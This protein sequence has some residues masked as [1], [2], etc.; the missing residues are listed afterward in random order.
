MAESEGR[1]SPARSEFEEFEMT[2]GSGGHAELHPELS[3]RRDPS[4]EQSR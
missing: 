1:C 4:D 3:E 2:R